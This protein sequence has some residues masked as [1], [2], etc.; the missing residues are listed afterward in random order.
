[1]CTFANGLVAIAVL[2]SLDIQ[3]KA[4]DASKGNNVKVIDSPAAVSSSMIAT[5]GRQLPP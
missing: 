2:L 3:A 1:M 5:V 4:P